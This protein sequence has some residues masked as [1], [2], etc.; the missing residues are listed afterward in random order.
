[1]QDR[2]FL[3]VGGVDGRSHYIDIGKG[4]ASEA[5]PDGCIVR[6][7]LRNTEPT[8]APQRRLHLKHDPSATERFAETHVRRLETVR[9]AA[10]SFNG[11]NATLIQSNQAR[12]AHG[13]HLSLFL[14]MPRRCEATEGAQISPT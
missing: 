10:G 1:M 9:H 13:C 5:T 4:E 12:S 14:P 3:I 8:R 11:P 2:H 6:V 7:T